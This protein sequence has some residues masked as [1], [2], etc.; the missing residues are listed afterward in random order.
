[1]RLNLKLRLV[2]RGFFYIFEIINLILILIN[3]YQIN[4]RIIN[5]LY[6]IL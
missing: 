5:D 6:R 3:I 2:G 1:M 4:L